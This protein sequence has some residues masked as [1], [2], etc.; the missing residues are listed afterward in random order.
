MKKSIVATRLAPKVISLFLSLVMLVSITAGIDFSAC[1]T[2][3]NELNSSD[4]FLKQETSTTCTLCSATMMLRRYSMLRGDSNWKSI[5]ESSVKQTAWIN[6]TG[7]KWSFS[8]SNSSIKS[9]SVGHYSLPGGSSNNAKIQEELKKSPE[10]IVIYNQSVPHAVLLTDYTNGVYYC[11]DPAAG[12]GKGRIPLSK[13]YK[14]SISNVASY[15]KVTS[16]AVSGPTS[17]S[18]LGAPTNVKV[19]AAGNKLKVTWNGVSGANCY[20]VIVTEPNGSQNW[21]HASS[22]SKD[23][24]ITKLG[25]YKVEVQSLYRPD[26]STTGQIVGAHS[27]IVTCD[28]NL[29][30]PTNVKAEISGN[31]FKITWNM[32]SGANCYDVIVKDPT[33]ATNWFHS[34]ANEKIIPIGKPGTYKFDVQSLY[35]PNGSSTGQIVGAHSGE[36]T[37]NLELTAPQNVRYDNNG[38]TF[39]VYWD[40]V[41]GATCY[42]VVVTKPD[43]ELAWLHTHENHA[44]TN[45]FEYGKYSFWI[46]GIYRTSC[47]DKSGQIGGVHTPDFTFDYQPSH[48]HE[49]DKDYTVDKQPT[50][51]ENGSKS[52]HCKT[53][54]ETKDTTKIPSISHDFS[55]WETKTE[56]TPVS[57]GTE[58]RKCKNCGYTETRN[59]DYIPV[60]DED[61]PRISM[62][63]VN[64]KAGEEVEVQ[65]KLENNPGVTSLRLVVNYDEDALEMTGFTFGDAL[66]SMNKATSQNYGNGYSF[67]M[68]SATADLIDCGT[69]ATIKFKV[70]ENA[71]EGEYPIAITYD[72]DDIFNLN[73]DCIGFDIE[74]GAVN[75]NSYLLGDLNDDGKINM[76]DVV[77]LQQVV[78]GWNVAYNKDAADYNGD[79]K[80]NMRDIVALQQYING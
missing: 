35:R 13:S 26:G 51:T 47:P 38:G 76:R 8:Y 12:I 3:F 65:V 61:A 31:N 25:T 63:G 74:N 59:I 17:G 29:F 44:S 14:V 32:V 77:L 45:K 58:I 67:S 22:N 55:K 2:T 4:V 5:T 70:N 24:P 18:S 41:P 7:L 80:I 43:G 37:Y 49:W 72:P 27:S 46:Q 6:G 33:G 28:V 50:C 16:S 40:S 78:N 34:S 42:D 39:N 21:W 73:G 23:I 1:A 20:D 54:S 62:A 75:V 11:A 69:L 64:A 15:W 56:A 52:I 68:Y 9:I 48:T 60:Y 66:S 57:D 79:G 71:E 53:C 30:G 36:I 10:G 19:S